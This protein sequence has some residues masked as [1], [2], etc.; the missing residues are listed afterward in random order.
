ML[1]KYLTKFLFHCNCWC[2][3]VSQ[4]LPEFVRTVWQVLSKL[5]VWKGLGVD[6]LTLLARSDVYYYQQLTCQMTWHVDISNFFFFCVF[7]LLPG[8]I[9]LTLVN[10]FVQIIMVYFYCKPYNVWLKVFFFLF[11][12]KGL[13]LIVW[14]PSEWVIILS[15]LALYWLYAYFAALQQQYTI[16]SFPLCCYLCKFTPKVEICRKKQKVTAVH[17]VVRCIW[18]YIRTSPPLQI[19]MKMSS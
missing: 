18:T 12:S 9:S 15:L 13:C 3:L 16:S 17:M 2:R 4:S 11:F 6:L 19:S 5:S 7:N 14:V 1:W 8:Y 10:T